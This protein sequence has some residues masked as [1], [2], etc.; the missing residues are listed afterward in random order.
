[1]A[2]K[3][4]DILNALVTL[5]QTGEPTIG[6]NTPLPDLTASGKAVRLLDG[7]IEQTEAFLNPPTY[8]FTMRPVAQLVISG[9]TDAERDAAIDTSLGNLLTA[10]AGANDLGGLSTDIRPQPPTGTP[11]EFFGAPNMKA[12]ELVIEIDYWSDTTAG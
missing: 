9:G 3:G 4:E 6:R 5:L 8:E 7:D 2:R 10:L 11:K 1:M 12:A